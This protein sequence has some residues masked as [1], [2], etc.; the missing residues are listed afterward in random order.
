MILGRTRATALAIIFASSA[1]GTSS[2]AGATSSVADTGGTAGTGAACEGGAAGGTGAAAVEDPVRSAFR[3]R[4]RSVGFFDVGA[5]ANPAG[6]LALALPVSTVAVAAA[7]GAVAAVARASAGVGEDGDNEGAPAA[8]V[9]LVVGVGEG[10][11]DEGA[12]AALDVPV[13][14]AALATVGGNDAE[15][16]SADGDGA[17]VD[18]PP[19]RVSANPRPPPT[20]ASTPTPTSH[21]VAERCLGAAAISDALAPS[22][23]CATVGACGVAAPCG[24]ATAE[25]PAGTADGWARAVGCGWVGDAGA[26]TTGAERRSSRAMRSTLA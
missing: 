16:V 3:R 26:A 25:C 6:G 15:L 19:P 2:A 7:G 9:V 11:D 4:S 17:V 18:S 21:G 20:S 23:V 8:F 1:S 5:L 14:G 13:A 24:L 22:V 10:G 12:L